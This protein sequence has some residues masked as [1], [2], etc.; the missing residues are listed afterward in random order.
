MLPVTHGIPYTRRQILLYTVLLVLCTLIPV[1]IGMSGVD[2]SIWRPR[3]RSMRAFFTWP[4][5]FT[6]AFG[7]T[8]PFE[9]F[10]SPSLT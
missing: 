3:S 7:P 9:P 10:V 1:V 2:W 8:F 4:W 6:E 5:L